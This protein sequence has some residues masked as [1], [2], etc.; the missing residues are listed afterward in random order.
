[1][2][3]ELY[4]KIIDEAATIPEI[5]HIAFS[6]LGEPLLDRFLVERVAYAR[7]ARPDWTPFE[8][9]T[10][11][12]YLTPA[13]FEA[14]RDAGIDSLTISLNA[15][16]PEQHEKIMG[17]KG[18]F[19][20]IVA[21]AKYAIANTQGK[22]EVIVKAVR[23]EDTFDEVDQ[24]KFHMMWGIR[25]APDV[26]P[27]NGQVVLEA[28]WA[29]GTRTIE[30]RVLD[31][32]SMCGRAVGQISI[33]WDGKVTMCCFDPLNTFP[34]GDLKTQTIREIYNSEKYTTFREDHFLNRAS[35]YELCAKC[36]RV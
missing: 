27:G 16:T 34:L 6:A 3:M 24:V 33:L 1:M 28:N 30:T 4:R 26:Y 18:K 13:K 15:V 11:G 2:S 25:L 19:G 22:C 14:L 23:N 36:T 12:T 10:N 9:Y 29:G 17:I 31:P 8:V 7:K 20:Q 32:D 21:N 5:T 35:K